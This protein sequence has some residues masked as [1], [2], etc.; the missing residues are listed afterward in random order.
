MASK[1]IDW[2]GVYV[3]K[4]AKKKELVV[5]F[6]DVLIGASGS[7]PELPEPTPDCPDMFVRH[8]AN[9]LGRRE[10]AVR[11]YVPLNMGFSL[12]QYPA[13]V[14]EFY[15]TVSRRYATNYG[16]TLKV[17]FEPGNSSWAPEYLPDPVLVT[18]QP[19]ETDGTVEVE[20]PTRSLPA[21]APNGYWPSGAAVG[22]YE[23]FDA[24]IIES[25]ETICGARC[26]ETG[27]CSI[28]GEG[29][30]SGIYS[31]ITCY[32]DDA[33]RV[34]VVLGLYTCL[35]PDP[36][37]L[38]ENGRAVAV[39]P[40]APIIECSEQDCDALTNIVS[41]AT[42]NET[43]IVVFATGE[44]EIPN[45]NGFYPNP[46]GTESVFEN[47]T[48][49]LRTTIQSSD[50]KPCG[51]IDVS[52][53]RVSSGGSGGQFYAN[54]PFTTFTNNSI[55]DTNPNLTGA[56][57]PI[58]TNPY[59]YLYMVFDDVT[60]TKLEFNISPVRVWTP[61]SFSQSPNSPSIEITP[62]SVRTYINSSGEQDSASININSLS[63]LNG[64]WKIRWS[65]NLFSS[66]W[67][68]NFYS[69][70]GETTLK[71]ETPVGVLVS[72]FNATSATSAIADGISGVLLGTGAAS[73]TGPNISTF[74]TAGTGPI[75][76]AMSKSAD[77]NDLIYF[78]QHLQ[79]Y[80][81]PTYCERVV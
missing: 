71:V 76:L 27:I 5:N 12:S 44:G 22:V 62:T 26:V 23:L 32:S 16:I 28:D 40:E 67:S 21:N 20:I 13:A 75:L 15:I 57:G 2:D 42:E 79:G 81:P 54:H 19:G 59:I 3:T 69:L 72:S 33:T 48:A 10:D 58:I 47:A 11:D 8:Y 66:A 1:S 34:P 18:I 30:S 52:A 43:A 77:E 50:Y 53:L 74:A 31:D 68:G 17:G 9:S 56:S 70:F 45:I 51:L 39:A 36:L 64:W 6:V 35:L 7:T 24:V 49:F 80:T 60:A 65:E 46:A 14:K 4:D 29:Q 73:Y 25:P 38:P 63:E 78:S 41:S 37:P 55:S 61:T